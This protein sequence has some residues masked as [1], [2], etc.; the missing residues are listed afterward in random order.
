MIIIQW[1][2]RNLSFSAKWTWN[3]ELDFFFTSA[4]SH[5]TEHSNRLSVYELLKSGNGNVNHLPIIPLKREKRSRRRIKSSHKWIKLL[6]THKSEREW[7]LF[8]GFLS[9]I[10]NWTQETLNIYNFSKNLPFKPSWVS[11]NFINKI[12]L[13][14]IHFCSYFTSLFPECLTWDIWRSF[15]QR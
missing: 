15:V 8:A 9:S 1:K 14:F 4:S 5:W 6:F 12:L 7:N 13:A 10:A 2:L 3:S 11:S